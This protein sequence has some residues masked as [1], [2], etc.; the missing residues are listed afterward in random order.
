MAFV[1]DQNHDFPSY[2]G[3]CMAC[4]HLDT[5]AG[6]AVPEC[7][8]FPTGIPEEIWRGKHDHRTPYPGDHGI[9]FE[10][11]GAPEG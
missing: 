3:P 1:I 11:I 8:A 9:Q 4:R 6:Y 2:S 5:D 7:A 10:R